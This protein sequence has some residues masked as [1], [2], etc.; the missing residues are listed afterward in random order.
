[1]N[2]LGNGFIL[3]KSCNDIQLLNLRFM[4]KNSK[5]QGKVMTKSEKF[6]NRTAQKY[7]RKEKNEEST[8]GDYVEKINKYLNKDDSILDFGC[9]TGLIAIGLAGNVK[10]I[11][12]IDTSSALIEIAKNNT[13][14]RNIKNIE[15]S[16][17]S[18]FDQQYKDNSFD[19]ILVLYIFHLL[20]DLPS[21]MKRLHQLLKPEGIV[22]SSTP[23]MGDKNKFLST[24]LKF[25]GFFGIV[26][27]I[28]VFTI[29]ELTNQFSHAGLNIVETELIDTSGQQYFVT[30]KK[31]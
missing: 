28:N 13:S 25:A 3:F 7:N 4:K 14:E 1:M 2:Y 27:N 8:Y 6:W 15:H 26:P 9:G 31:N 12:A 29:A 21:V 23:C 30:A 22:I 17:S 11:L 5:E 18:L 19:A 16:C 20:E 10:N 24:I